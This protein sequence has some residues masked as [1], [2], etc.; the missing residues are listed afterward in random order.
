MNFLGHCFVCQQHTHLMAGN[1]AGDSFK[2]QLTNFE[3][4]PKHILDGITL[5]RFIDDYTDSSDS[6]K[7]VA[8]LF[9]ENGIQKI[10]FIACDILLDHYLAQNWSNYTSQLY[11]QFIQHIYSTVNKELGRL[12]DDFKF[13]YSKMIDYN[14]LEIYPQEDGIRKILRQLSNRMQFDHDLDKCMDI[15]L[16]HKT[17]IDSHFKTFLSTI[18]LATDKF[19]LESNMELS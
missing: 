16:Q 2:G 3:N 10:S 15:Y 1:L 14:W 9:Q 8:H 17:V 6:I 4:L 18:I 7:A 13:L 11:L 12:P 5:H 19:I